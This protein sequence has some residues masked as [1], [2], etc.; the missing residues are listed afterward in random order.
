[1]SRLEGARIVSP[2]L[3]PRGSIITTS[4]KKIAY[5]LIRL[6]YTQLKQAAAAPAAE[7]AFLAKEDMYSAY[8][9]FDTILPR[10]LWYHKEDVVIENGC[11]LKGTLRDTIV[12]KSN[13]SLVHIIF[14]EYGPQEAKRF[15]NNYNWLMN[16]WMQ[17]SGMSVGIKDLMLPRTMHNSIR[18]HISTTLAHLEAERENLCIVSRSTTMQAKCATEFRAL[19]TQSLTSMSN[20]IEQ[21][22]KKH[23][24][25]LLETNRLHEM[26]KSCPRAK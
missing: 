26:V 9:I 13:H 15:I 8:Q 25:E 3:Y 22:I 19:E 1:L 18:E 24:S 20:F 21:M 16:E 11:L 4:D 2:P 5:Q 7:Y 14:A 10:T 23:E 6:G 12:G 17:C